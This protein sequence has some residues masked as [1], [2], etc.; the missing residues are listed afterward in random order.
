MNVVSGSAENGCVALYAQKVLNSKD[1]KG[2]V[3]DIGDYS[4]YKQG[5]EY[6]LYRYNGSDK[7]LTLP[8]LIDGG[9]SYKIGRRVFRDKYVV[10]VVM[11]ESV[12]AIDDEAFSGCSNLTSVVI[13]ENVSTIGSYAFSSCSSLT[14]VVIGEN[15]TSIGNSA[16]SNCSSLTSI[17]IPEKV[18]A[19]SGGAFV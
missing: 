19:I 1:E 5:G 8:G 14:S 15:V 10:S 12:I 11:P 4:F 2:E 9:H 16:F 13:G 17:I 7:E 6:I 3:F 18:T